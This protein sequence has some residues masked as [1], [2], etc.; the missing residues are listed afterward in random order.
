MRW[1]ISNCR[2][3]M[4]AI[5]HGTPQFAG[6]YD[7][8]Y[9]QPDLGRVDEI[10]RRE[11]VRLLANMLVVCNSHQA[12]REWQ[13]KNST[14]I[15]HGFSPH[16]Y[17]ATFGDNGV[18]T[19]PYAALENRPHYNG[20]YIFRRVL[21]LVNG[22]IRISALTVP[23]PPRGYNQGTQEWAESKFRNYTR[24]LGRY[25]VYLN[26]SLRSPMP[27]TRG[28][29]MMVGL[30]TVNMRNHD[31]DLFLRSGVNGFIADSADE[32]AE[33][34]RFLNKN[35]LAREKMGGASRMTALERFNQERYLADWNRLL[36]QVVA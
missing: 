19:M 25:S 36:R 27:R 24:E 35:P 26:T 20:L 31:V 17:P 18:L 34:L 23:D 14:V 11:V 4:V 21:E 10:S 13:F 12:Q 2:L 30:V 8:D 33:Q 7:A 15:W 16:E 6:Q 3:P 9:V 22:S 28:E 32:M 1:F 29:A 5:C